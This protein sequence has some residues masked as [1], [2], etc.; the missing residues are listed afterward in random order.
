MW[1]VGKIATKL[2][3]R[4][5][6]EILALSAPTVLTML[7]HTL[8]WNVD[9][10]M[11]GHVSSLALGAAGLGGLITWTCYCMINGLSRITSTFVSQAN[12]RGDDN[13]IADFTWQGIYIAILGGI[14]LTMIGQESHWILKLTGHTAEIQSTTYT[15]I[16]IRMISAIG[17]QIVMAIS[18]FFQGQKDVKTPMWAGIIANAINIGLDIILIFGFAGIAMGGRTWFEIEAM[19]VRGAAIGTTIAVFVNA[20]ILVVAMIQPKYRKRFAIHKPRKPSLPVLK[21]ITRVGFPLSLGEL[22]DMIS[23]SVFTILIGKYGAEALAANQIT[24]QIL[25][26]SFMP[27]WGITVAATVLVGNEIGK[28]DPDRAARFGK[29]TYL[30]VLYY[31]IFLAA[32]IILFRDYLF[33]IFTKDPMVLTLAGGLAV[34]AAIFQFGDGLRMLGTGVLQGAGDTAYPTRL[35]FVILIGVFIPLTGYIVHVRD[36]GIIAAWLGGAFSY[37]LM[38]VGVYF[39]YRSGKWRE[40]GVLIRE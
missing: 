33:L 25:S 8:M 16:R 27:T 37:L 17:T 7:S 18:G 14:L 2:G 34:C 38:A 19:G 15:Y 32:M 24:I 40:I 4:H 3:I 31:M 11:L 29:E 5:G 20:I 6:R 9:S 26:F 23:F 10:A 12:G 35:A 22:I 21:K 13:S 39:R 30:I 36:G 28:G 1:I